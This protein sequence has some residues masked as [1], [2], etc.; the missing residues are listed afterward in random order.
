[1]VYG[2]G[3]ELVSLRDHR[4][5][6]AF[7][8]A[9]RS[10]YKRP[11][12]VSKDVIPVA[13]D[14]G[15]ESISLQRRVHCEPHAVHINGAEIRLFAGSPSSSA[16]S[17]QTVS[18]GASMPAAHPAKIASATAQHATLLAKGRSKFKERRT[19]AGYF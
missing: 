1:V 3:I 15:F 7:R 12:A 16:K 18:S 9:I 11:R 19:A 2:Q 8:N 13:G 4:T 6:D 17:T 14:R 10:R 5:A